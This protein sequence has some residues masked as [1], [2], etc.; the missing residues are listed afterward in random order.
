[1]NTRTTQ[2]APLALALAGLAGFTTGNAHADIAS[3]NP[4]T[5][6]PFSISIS[7]RLT[8]LPTASPSSE[9]FDPVKSIAGSYTYDTVS[10][11][12]PVYVDYKTTLPQIGV[13]GKVDVFVVTP[14]TTNTIKHDYQRANIGYDYT[15]GALPNAAST[16][17]KVLEISG[18]ISRKA[19]EPALPG[20]DTYLSFDFGVAGNYQLVAPNT[21]IPRLALLDMVVN[22]TSLSPVSYSETL[23][24]TSSGEG[25]Y[26]LY[27][28]SG[29]Y[30]TAFTDG[31]SF[32]AKMLVGVD[33]D[34]ATA[35]DSAWFNL[36]LS[37]DSSVIIASV[38]TSSKELLESVPIPALA[39]PVPEAETY[40]MMLAG[41]GLVGFAAR[42][43]KCLDAADYA[44]M[45][46]INRRAS[47]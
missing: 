45:S 40:A 33:V 2:I 8:N 47:R 39:A 13:E 10:D 21:T 16:T 14:Q 46:R 3:S 25:D 28:S 38:D 11:P 31:L 43:R 5:E 4:P 19:G 23:T 9:V 18:S 7:S 42:R 41:L 27:R 12:M 15:N 30:S 17:Q 26:M 20:V 29:S 6:V 34:A 37:Q 36:G 1:M 35:I 32:Y 24:P 22:G 44:I